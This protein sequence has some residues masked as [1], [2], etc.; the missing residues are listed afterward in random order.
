MAG[1]IDTC[2]CCQGYRA[3]EE[4]RKGYEIY[5]VPN[6][7]VTEQRV[8]DKLKLSA[9][10]LGTV[11]YRD[12]FRFYYANRN[13]IN[14][15]LEYHAFWSLFKSLCHTTKVMMLLMLSHTPDK[16]VFIKA[17]M[18]GAWDGARGD[19]G[20]NELYVPGRKD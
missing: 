8:T 4:V 12:A 14:V 6:S 17:I 7:K 20:R 3:A 16:E 1:N 18:K 11:T 2:D 10:G 5:W 19:L 13:Q 9:L 15:C